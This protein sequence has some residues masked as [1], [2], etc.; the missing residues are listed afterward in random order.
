MPAALWVCVPICVYMQDALWG[1]VCV[2]VNANELI[3]GYV[4]GCVCIHTFELHCGYVG[5]W[6]G[7][8]SR[9]LWAIDGPPRGSNDGPHS[10]I[11]TTAV[12]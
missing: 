12:P 3:C 1:C 2:C 10:H 11:H 5:D 7:W 9:L 4:C 6:L 8:P